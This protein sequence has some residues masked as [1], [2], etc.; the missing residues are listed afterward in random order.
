MFGLLPW[1]VAAAAN[2]DFMSGGSTIKP[3]NIIKMTPID[4]KCSFIQTDRHIT[5][6]SNILIL[7]FK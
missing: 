2:D 6:A 1:A 4:K 7:V 5:L 3:T